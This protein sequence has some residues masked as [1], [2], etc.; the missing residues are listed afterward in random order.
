MG[1]LQAPHASFPIHL[2]F[3]KL[4][5][6]ADPLFLLSPHS[7]LNCSQ[8]FCTIQGLSARASLLLAASLS[9]CKEALQSC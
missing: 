2:A 9:D 1:L 7:L 8:T 3:K 6:S 5:L 4:A